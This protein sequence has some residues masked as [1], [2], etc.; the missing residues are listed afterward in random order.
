M[1]DL[2]DLPKGIQGA[3]LQAPKV[4]Y[5]FKKSFGA[6]TVQTFFN[7]QRNNLVW[8]GSQTQKYGLLFS[9]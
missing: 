7:P 9:P 3:L 6:G 5:Y 8:N 2:E 4:V 1:D